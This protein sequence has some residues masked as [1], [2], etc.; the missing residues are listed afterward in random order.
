MLKQTLTRLREKNQGHFQG[1]VFILLKEK[2]QFI[3]WFYVAISH[4]LCRAR[5]E[6]IPLFVIKKNNKIVNNKKVY[7]NRF[8]RIVGQWGFQT[9]S[10]YSNKNFWELYFWQKTQ[11]THI[12]IA[13]RSATRG[14]RDC[15]VW[16]IIMYWN[17][18]VDSF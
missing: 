16:Y 14:S 9:H 1:S 12:S 13:P 18:K 5:M 17:R 7:K 8:I 4:F 11:W 15:H 6:I 2:N 3:S 10:D